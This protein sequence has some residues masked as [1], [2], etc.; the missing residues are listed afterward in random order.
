M[1]KPL[2]VFVQLAFSIHLLYYHYFATPAFGILT[3][4]LE[5]RDHP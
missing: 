2:I 4:Q 5:P 3:T 1:L